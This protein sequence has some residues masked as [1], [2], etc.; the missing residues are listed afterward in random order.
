MVTSIVS[1][2]MPSSLVQKLRELAKQ[3]HFLDVSEEVRSIIKIQIRK[4]KIMMGEARPIETE[5]KKI[6]PT[7]YKTENMVKEELVKRLKTMIQELENE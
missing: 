6:K 7:D 4:Q 1:V 5:T 3:N 2:R